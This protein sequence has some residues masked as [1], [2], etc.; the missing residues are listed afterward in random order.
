MAQEQPII[1]PP[2]RLETDYPV[3]DTDPYGLPSS[4]PTVHIKRAF[5]YA[6][7]EDWIVGT[8]VAAFGPL[9][10]LTLERFT[11]SFS[12]KGTFPPILRLSSA[13]GVL[14]GLGIVYQRSCLRFYGF[15]ENKREEEMDMREMVDKVKRGEPLYGVSDLTPYMQGVAARNSRY[16]SLMFQ[17]VPW[18]NVANHNQHGVDTAKYYQ[19]AEREL[20]ILSLEMSAS[21][22]LKPKAIRF[23]D[24]SQKEPASA[25][26]QLSTMED[27][28]RFVEVLASAHDEGQEAVAAHTV[29]HQLSEEVTAGD[30][31]AEHDECWRHLKAES[32]SLKVME[33]KEAILLD[34]LSASKD[35]VGGL[36][37][38]EKVARKLVA[39]QEE[40]GEGYFKDAVRQKVYTVTVKVIDDSWKALQACH[41]SVRDKLAEYNSL[42]EVRVEIVVGLGT[43][44]DGLIQRAKVDLHDPSFWQARQVASD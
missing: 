1:I 6:R 38:V 10:M 36:K 39:S 29:E 31:R 5:R 20:P 25:L 11:P 35:L 4:S 24:D 28:R 9:F 40:H 41:L 34:Y 18:V 37:S 15:T 14:A 19:Q 23:F 2:K 32:V 12:S 33:T 30:K 27:T 21:A 13:M 7:R 26:F 44:S 43:G 22:E 3:I 16:A 8:G 42:G 17:I